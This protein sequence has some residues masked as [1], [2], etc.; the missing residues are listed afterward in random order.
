LVFFFLSLSF[1]FSLCFENKQT[2]EGAFLGQY[3]IA[4]LVQKF[5]RPSFILIAL[6]IVIFSSAISLLAIRL[7][8]LIHSFSTEF[9]TPCSPGLWFLGGK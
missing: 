4:R 3:L 2:N 9:G 5:N 6:T 7:P 8:E 1:S